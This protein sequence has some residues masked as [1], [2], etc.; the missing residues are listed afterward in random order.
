MS[1]EI[2]SMAW[3]G[4][5]LPLPNSQL[6]GELSPVSPSAPARLAEPSL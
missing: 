3:T 1:A 4:W 2:F 6:S 5:V